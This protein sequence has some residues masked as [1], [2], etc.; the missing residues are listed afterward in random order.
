M[1]VPEQQ[2]HH[3][4]TGLAAQIGRS[5]PRTIVFRD[6]LDETRVDQ[7]A[8]GG[9]VASRRRCVIALDDGSQLLALSSTRRMTVGADATVIAVVIARVLTLAVI[10]EI[11]V[12]VASVTDVFAALVVVFVAPEAAQ[13]GRNT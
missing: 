5:R 2:R 10:V 8:G 1:V 12:A 13:R 4:R 11:G 6:R 3:S 7:R 9:A